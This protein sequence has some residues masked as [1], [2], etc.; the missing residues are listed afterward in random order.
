MLKNNQSMMYF[1]YSGRKSK[2]LDCMDSLVEKV[3]TRS[4]LCATCRGFGSR[5]GKA[6]VLSTIAYSG[7]QGFNK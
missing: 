5:V 7:S 1:F 2:S 3:N 6:L 4:L